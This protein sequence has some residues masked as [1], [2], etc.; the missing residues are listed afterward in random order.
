ME[1]INDVSIID[2]YDSSDE[3]LDAANEFENRIVKLR[4]SGQDLGLTVDGEWEMETL[5]DG[6]M[7]K[8][9]IKIYG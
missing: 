8:T 5:I 2:T 6:F 1:A 7:L 9:T 4:D 3:A